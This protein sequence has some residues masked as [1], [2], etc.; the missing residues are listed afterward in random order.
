MIPVTAIPGAMLITYKKRAL[1]FQIEVISPNWSCVRDG[2]SLLATV[3]V[4][5][6]RHSTVMHLRANNGGENLVFRP[7]TNPSQRSFARSAR[8]SY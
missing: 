3:Q 2:F 8:I 4:R 5:Q 7:I 6:N 1:L